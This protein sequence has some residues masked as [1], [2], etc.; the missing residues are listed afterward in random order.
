MKS[1]LFTKTVG[2]CAIA[3]VGLVSCGDRSNTAQTDTVTPGETV[4][5]TDAPGT[6]T[7]DIGDAADQVED[8]LD[9]DETLKPFDLDAEGEDNTILIEG[10]VDD[11]TQTILA[12]DVARQIAPDFTIV[13]RVKVKS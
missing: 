7:V 8:V 4:T 11:A 10:T 2:L 9:T 5:Q 13:N 3:L 6:Q 12:E 1:H